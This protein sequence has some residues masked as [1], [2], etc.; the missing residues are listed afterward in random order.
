MERRK[1]LGVEFKRRDYYFYGEN[2]G[3]KDLLNSYHDWI[4]RIGYYSPKERPWGKQRPF[5][6]IP[7]PISKKR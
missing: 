6:F 1:L 3:I 4:L 7:N 5:D 2:F